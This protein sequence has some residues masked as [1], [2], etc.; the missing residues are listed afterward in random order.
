MSNEILDLSS[1]RREAESGEL[2]QQWEK[3]Q[4]HI[5]NFGAVKSWFLVWMKF[6]WS[7]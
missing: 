5:D 2:A 1:D 3:A 4:E 7:S 6:V